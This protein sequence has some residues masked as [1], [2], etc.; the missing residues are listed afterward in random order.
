MAGS[1]IVLDGPDG[2]GTTLH[3][4]LLAD[5]LRAQ[6]KDVL[7]TAEPSDGEIGTFIRKALAT[8][9]L[10]PAGLQL[11]FCADRAD[12]LARVVEPAMK[13]GSTVITDRYFHSTLAY[14]SAL[15]LDDS[16][17]LTLNDHFIRPSLTL[18][19][20]PP[21]AVALDRLRTRTTRDQLE[22]E[23]LQQKVHKAYRALADTDPSIV[24]IDTSGDKETVAELIWNSVNSVL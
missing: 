9:R 15:G 23:D 1:L 5:R 12:H 7:H 18:F 19:L 21:L 22:D 20:L 6:G 16:W 13:N 11:L 4:R 24:V 14:G 3:S 17:L 10:S 8:M 2:S